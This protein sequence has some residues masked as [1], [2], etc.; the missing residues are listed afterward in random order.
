MSTEELFNKKIAIYGT[1]DIDVD[2]NFGK[3]DFYIN[4]KNLNIPNKIATDII[5]GKLACDIF[6]D[7]KRKSDKFSIV[8]AGSKLFMDVKPEEDNS[9]YLLSGKRWLPQNY[10][11]SFYLVENKEMAEENLSVNKVSS[12]L[13]SAIKTWNIPIFNKTQPVII[14]NNPNLVYRQ[15]DKKNVIAFTKA[16]SSCLATTGI[17]YRANKINGY[18]PIVECDISF[19]TNLKWGTDG[20][21][22]HYDFQSTVLHELGHVLGLS[23]LYRTQL[24]DKKQIMGYYSGRRYLGNGDL[25]GI[26]KLY[27]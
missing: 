24:D 1:S 19:N 27:S 7:Y 22:G 8:K 15:Y 12:E 18:C 9:S 2:G 25:V 26:K 13:I 16:T 6:I 11:I 20:A 14:S 17:F 3:S 23:D 21:K 10:G 4:G 5:N